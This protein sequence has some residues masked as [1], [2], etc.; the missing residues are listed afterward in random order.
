MTTKDATLDKN[1]ST[2]I[3]EIGQKSYKIEQNEGE[4]L[5]DKDV[6]L[7]NKVEDRTINFNWKDLELEENLAQ[8][9]SVKLC[10]LKQ[11]LVSSL[12]YNTE[13]YI[14]VQ[15]NTPISSGGHLPHCRWC[16]QSCESCK[17]NCKS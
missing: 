2:K 10:A 7:G 5:N 6:R 8:L 16:T 12:K 15:Y 1:T 9:T 14:E 11:N 17:E 13:C 3:Y 4:R